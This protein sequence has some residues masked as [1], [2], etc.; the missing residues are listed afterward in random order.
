MLTMGCMDVHSFCVNASTH[1][2]NPLRCPIPAPAPVREPAP[3]A[4]DATVNWR[5]P[6]KPR[7]CTKKPPIVPFTN[8]SPALFVTKKHTSLYHFLPP[9]PLPHFLPNKIPHLHHFVPTPPP[10]AHIFYQKS[11][12]IG[13]NSYQTPLPAPFLTNP[14]PPPPQSVPILT[15]KN[16]I[17]T[18][19]VPPPRQGLDVFLVRFR[20]FLVRGGGFF[21]ER[22]GLFWLGLGFFVTFFGGFFGK[23]CW[24]G[25]GVCG[26]VW[27]FSEYPFQTP[28]FGHRFQTHNYFVAP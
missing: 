17:S 10:P 19:F 5:I 26:G 22:N 21:F 8:H 4:P 6:K 18:N 16:P 28:D 13:T 15:K 9:A 7:F 2:P 25:G 12:P 14:T 27:V 11:S 23:N 24:G 1:L 3:A 20:S